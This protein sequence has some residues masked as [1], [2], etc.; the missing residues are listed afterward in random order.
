MLLDAVVLSAR[1]RGALGR[2]WLV[3]A[4]APARAWMLGYF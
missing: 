4:P 3:L 1:V 2:A